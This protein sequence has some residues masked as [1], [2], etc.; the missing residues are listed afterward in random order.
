MVIDAGDPSSRETNRDISQAFVK[1]GM[2]GLDDG[3]S[4][5]RGIFEPIVL[6][7]HWVEKGR[8][9]I[10]GLGKRGEREIDVIQVLDFSIK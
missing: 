5:G 9:S 2:G 8:G 3:E 10:R 6:V 1:F 4:I 7:A